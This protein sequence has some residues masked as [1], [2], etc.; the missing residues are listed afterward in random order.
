[1]ELKNIIITDITDWPKLAKWLEDNTDC[2]WSASGDPTNYKPVGLNEI[3]ISS[4]GI[5]SYSIQS[6]CSKHKEEYSSYTFITQSEFEAKYMTTTKSYQE[7]Q[8]EWIKANNLKVGDKVK[9]VKEVESYK[10]G[11]GNFWT[12]R[13]KAGKIHIIETYFDNGVALSDG[14]RYPYFC[15]EKVQ[16][17]KESTKEK[18][19][20]EWFNELPEP[21]RT[22]ALN[23]TSER[24][25]KLFSKSMADALCTGFIWPDFAGDDYWDPVFI[26]YVKGTPLP[27]HSIENYGSITE[28]PNP[29]SI[30]VAEDSVYEE[31]KKLILN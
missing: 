31:W 14:Y 16:E 22:Q 6:Y 20:E 28:T 1:M 24:S 9:V 10:D 13:M 3:S 18:T 4:K 19:I 11:W 17:V 29:I 26:H 27:N 2:I 5:I 25:K 21:Y 7:R 12:E 30:K 15:L 23:N 8:E